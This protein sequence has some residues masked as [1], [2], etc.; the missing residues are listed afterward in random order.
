MVSNDSPARLE[1]VSTPEAIIR[2]VYELIS[3]NA[4]APRDWTR[5]KSLYF[6]NARLI[7]FEADATGRALPNVMSIDQ[8]IDTRSF[9]FENES[10]FEWET[11]SRKDVCGSMAHVWSSYEAGRTLHGP[12][13]R[14]GVN[15]IQL[16]NDG[17][18]WW[19]LSTAWDA[20]D[21]RTS[22]EK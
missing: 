3:G 21:A 15:S 20:V 16:F 1:D 22:V 18:R 10:F 13:I 9:F 19:I 12:A 8:F 14:R 7:P 5:L 17:T 11:E 4:G 2:T 6:P